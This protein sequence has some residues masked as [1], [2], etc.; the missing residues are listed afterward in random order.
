MRLFFIWIGLR[1]L[2][3][4]C[5]AG[6]EPRAAPADSR[7]GFCTC[8]AAS[9]SMGDAACECPE[10]AAREGQ[11]F[12]IIID[13]GDDTNFWPI[14]FGFG[15]DATR[16]TRCLHAGFPHRL[17]EWLLVV[18]W[19][20]VAVV[21]GAVHALPSRTAHCTCIQHFKYD[22][23]NRSLPTRLPVHCF[24]CDTRRGSPLQARLPPA[25]Q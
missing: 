17:S 16:R 6:H 20:G 1:H 22:V 8:W 15:M 7:G 23:G 18:K 2:F 5:L 4:R 24:T 25:A 21:R 3:I 19:C 11:C 10:R 9:A 12:A 14:G 13:G